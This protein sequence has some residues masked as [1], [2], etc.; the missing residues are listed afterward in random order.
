MIEELPI[1]DPK[2]FVEVDELVA[3]SYQLRREEHQKE[4]VWRL[5]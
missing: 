2:R 3:E 4:M 5:W 1:W